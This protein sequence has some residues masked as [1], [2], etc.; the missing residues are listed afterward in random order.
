MSQ[1]STSLNNLGPEEKRKLLAA[2]LKE[3]AAA[4]QTA[5]LSYGQQ[6]WW[7]L[8]NLD[9]QSHACNVAFAAR[10][11]SAVNAT[12]LRAAFQ[13]LVDRHASLRT[14][15]EVRDGEPRQVVHAR[16]EVSFEEFD[17]S[18][19]GPEELFR[20]LVADSQRPFRLETGPVLRVSLYTQSPA[21]HLLLITAHHISIDLWSMVV[22]LHELR[23][24]YPAAMRGEAVQLAPLPLQYTDY[25]RWQAESLND[26]SG[27]RLWA[28][29]RE[30]LGGE[31]SPLELPATRPRQPGH[32]FHGRTL[33]F[34]LDAPL[35]R[36]LKAFSRQHGVT[37]YVTLLAAFKTLLYRYTAQEDILVGTLAATG[38]NRAEM[39]NLV[40]FLDNPLALRTRV[41]GDEPF[42]SLVQ[43]VGQTV[44]EA[45]EHQDYP[46]T[47]V[48]E[49]LRPRRDGG[50][51]PLF[52][53]MFILQRTQL[54]EEAA[55]LAVARGEAGART[56]LGGLVLESV[57]LQEQMTT[58][59]AGNLDLTLSM[60]ELNDGLSASF[61]FNADLFDEASAARMAEHFRQLL[62]GI[63]ARPDESVSRLPLLTPEEGRQMLSEW[64]AT[65]EQFPET[66]LL[67]QLFEE[68]AARVP[69]AVAAV[70]GGRRLSYGELNRRANQ[71]AHA[72]RKR[73]VGPGAVVGVCVERSLEMLVGLLG[74]L[75]AG[76]VYLPLDPAYPQERL[77]FMLED[78]RA[79]LVLS[80]ERL[81]GDALGHD[82]EVV[83][84][85]AEGAFAAESDENPDGVVTPASFAYIIY[86]SGST[87]RPKGVMIDHRGAANTIHDI[88]RRFGV[89]RGD[90]VLALSSLSFDLSV[91][92][93]FGTLAAGATVVIPDPSPTPD[94]AH[95]EELMSRERVTVWNSAPALMELFVTFLAGKPAA[96]FDSLRLMMFSGD[97]IPVTLPEQVRAFAPRAR[98]ISLGGATEASIWSIMYP[99]E[100]VDPAWKSIPYGRPMANQRFHV[101]D[102]ELQPVPAGVIGQLHIGGIG[103][104]QGYLNRP[105]LTAEKF[106]PDPFSGEPGARLYCTGDLGRYLEDGNIEFLGR[107][108]QQVKIHGFRIELGEI[109]AALTQHPSV[110][111]GVVIAQPNAHGEKRL[112]AYVVPEAEAADVDGPEAVV[113]YASQ[114]GW[115]SL[116]EAGHAYARQP[117]AEL[118]A[119]DLPRLT[120]HLNRLT[121]AY[122]SR[123]FRELGVF[124]RAGE[125]HTAE[126]LYQRFGVVPRYGKALRRWLHI[127]V[128]EGLLEQ[129]G[130]ELSSPAPLPDPPVAALWEDF[131][132]QFADE[133]VKETV[134]YFQL[135]GENLA[136]VLTGKV[137]PTQLLFREGASQVAENFYQEVFRFCNAVAREVVASAAH[138]LPPEGRLRI[139]EVGAGV[140]STTTWLLPVLPADRTDFTFTDIS[141]Y[142]TDLGRGLF[143]DYPFVEYRLLDI[144]RPPEE[145][146]FEPH[147]YDIIVASSVLHATLNIK[148]TLRHVR[149]LLSPRGVLLLIEETRFHRWFNVLGLQEGFDRFEDEDLRQSHP[150]LSAEQW[151]AA[152][153]SQ[154]FDDFESFSVKG[155]PSDSLGLDV[156]LGRASRAAAPPLAPVLREHLKTKLPEY[157]VPSAFVVLDSLPL[158]PNGKV[159]RRA[160]LAP[161]MTHDRAARPFVAPRTPVEEAL[162]GLW[163][164]VLGV[165]QVGTSDNFFELGGDSLLATQVA[166]QL[167]SLFSVDLPLQ[168]FFEKPTIAALAE[169]IEAEQQ[170]AG[171]SSPSAE[172][173]RPRDEATPPL[174]FAQQRLLFLDQLVPGSPFYNVHAAVRLKGELDRPLLERCFQQIVRRHESLRTTFV[175]EGEHPVQVIAPELPFEVPLVDLRELDGPAQQEGVRRLATEEAQ[176]PFDLARGPLLRATLLRL[177]EREHM[178]LLTVHHIV[179]DGWSLG[180]LL[181]ELDVLYRDF[182]AG[183]DSSLPALPIQYADFARWQREW[184]QGERLATQLGYWEKQLAGSRVLQLPTDRPRPAVQTFRGARQTF[185]YPPA[186]VESLKALGGREGTT[187]F[188]T[189]LATFQTLL[190]RYTNEEDIVVGS[191]I[192]NRNRAEFDRLIGFFVN[193]L[194][195]RADLSGNPTFRELLAQVRRMALEAYARQDLPFEKL[196]EELRPERN[197][198]HTPLFQVWFVLQ[199][200]PLPPLELPGLTLELLQVD[201][202]TSKFDLVLSLFETKQGLSATWIYNT[203]LFDEATVARMSRHYETL[204]AR[205]AADPG[206]RLARLQHLTAAEQLQQSQ[207]MTEKKKQS[208]NK[209]K[210]IKRRAVDIEEVEVVRSYH[211]D[212]C[213]AMPLVL[214]PTSPDTLD[215]ADWAADARPTLDAPLARHGALLLRGFGLS[216]ASDFERVASTLCPDLFGD[217]GDLPRQAVAGRVYGSTPYPAD[218]PILFHHESSQMHRWPRR[219]MFFC[220]E[221]SERG[222]QTPLADGRAV[223]RRLSPALRGGPA[224]LLH[225][226]TGEPVFFNQLLAHHASRLDEGVRES[227]VGLFGEGGLPRQVYYGDGGEIS[228]AEVEEV[229]EAYEAE[230]VDFAWER[231]DLLLVDNMMVAHGRRAYEGRRRV[232]VAMGRMFEQSDAV[233]AEFEAVGES[234]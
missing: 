165:E 130:E 23:E 41:R 80:Q 146:G 89:A 209:L 52:Q 105:G 151:Q 197:M 174:S 117:F 29:W 137:H 231:G 225:P 104:A 25:V 36:G 126:E 157:M 57:N 26:G 210:N 118:H 188:M 228:D 48:V 24:L 12:A 156:M 3:K 85:D 207:A 222:G 220:E 91:Y 193:A 177:G 107:M 212:S 168:N 101:L 102:D 201:D 167:Q 121:A 99:I 147:S 70:A 98:V 72:L 181:R 39:T 15:Y 94:P 182:Y 127:L 140:G 178:L 83:C 148:Q 50:R 87:G 56:D 166:A 233:S 43:S 136:A 32:S 111:E 115:E 30:R 161:G 77:S 46:F 218:R 71:L 229:L 152:M 35:T 93:I 1:T 219:I 142:F 55:L 205:A 45:F 171:E 221:P 6:A 16:Q 124:A 153:L 90:R 54:P 106:V 2:M 63:V 5:P 154:G 4:Q 204:L 215:A 123:A 14:T 37:L 133:Q 223:W 75:K 216:G 74:I 51:A 132:E 62:E 17:A 76:G 131:R 125:N 19:S 176:R 138:S 169:K 40:G 185:V 150:M 42:S 203:D 31:L 183:Q 189:L 7:F 234:A 208:L 88:N 213:P 224:A 108:D 184:M 28:Y 139:L 192:A 113:G 84:L 198:T 73:G 58:G 86:T 160:L 164:Q 141:R 179:F 159:D 191:P 110:R 227:L 163:R 96:R 170:S 67:H 109:E 10:V 195:L 190:H 95:W 8:Y 65:A 214:S 187:L 196:V 226:E 61:Q 79:L 143:A 128:E 199:N 202:G 149:S 211:L 33:V 129:R 34:G 145:Q 66:H 53:V 59:I 69:E 20:R 134:E 217:Y 11:S 78:A 194:A 92:D 206:A 230:A 122:V 100:R 44:L 112:A 82:S 60:I 49:R 47:M 180:V 103:V 22:L 172:A 97:W 200:A 232:L 81:V 116:L 135:C 175:R 144:E 114:A 186:L 21:S 9:P 68:Q 158:T 173:P 162:A 64:N 120:G 155:S 38:R 119:L 27:E 18:A 13:T